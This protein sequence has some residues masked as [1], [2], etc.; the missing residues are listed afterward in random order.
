MEWFNSLAGKEINLR[1][2]HDL[3]VYPAGHWQMSPVTHF[4]PFTHL[5]L[6]G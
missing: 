2:P 1:V 5:H 4:P 6:K 3:P